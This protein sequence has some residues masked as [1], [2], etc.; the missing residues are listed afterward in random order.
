MSE[1]LSKMRATPARTG[2][3]GAKAILHVITRHGELVTS[4]RLKSIDSQLK[5]ADYF[6]E[7]SRGYY[8]NFYYIISYSD[9][10]IVSK[11]QN[12]KYEIYPSRRK[13]KAFED[14]F[15]NWMAEIK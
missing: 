12:N 10:L 14:K 15:N 9:N 3:A 5:E 6:C 8:V 4:D 7:V 2:T 11:S 1:W 13:Y